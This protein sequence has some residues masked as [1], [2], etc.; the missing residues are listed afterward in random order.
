MGRN[1]YSRPLWYNYYNN[2]F[3]GEYNQFL[4]R[5]NN[6]LSMAVKYTD[7]N[8]QI[9]M[10]KSYIQFFETGDFKYF[11]DS[12]FHSLNSNNSVIDVYLGWVNSPDIRS[13]FIVSVTL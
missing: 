13:R 8:N 10:I 4:E 3:L 11:E 7:D 1:K 12:Q 2:C 9:N 6:N 5:V